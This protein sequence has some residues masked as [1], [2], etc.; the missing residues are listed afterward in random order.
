M[1]YT[2]T[3][4]I[5]NKVTD[6]SFPSYDL[7]QAGITH[8]VLEVDQTK[9]QDIGRGHHIACGSHLCSKFN[10]PVQYF[11]LH[12]SVA[13]NRYE[14]LTFPSIVTPVHAGSF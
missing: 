2:L 5:I 10:K 4:S 3:N 8:I 11:I 7:T 12:P 9:F 1:T 6:I 13:L 14:T